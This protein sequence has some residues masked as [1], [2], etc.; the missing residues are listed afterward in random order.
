MTIVE[1]I[2]LKLGIDQSQVGPGLSDFRGKVNTA[3]KEASEAFNKVTHS[4]RGFKKVLGDLSEQSPIL[5]AALRMAI[6][7]VG[8]TLMVAS[9]AFAYFNK[10]MEEGTARLDSLG[11]I[12]GMAFGNVKAAAKEAAREVDGLNRKF[13]EANQKEARDRTDR[14][15]GDAFNKGLKDKAS[16]AGQA[17]LNLGTYRDAALKRVDDAEGAGTISK[18]KAAATKANIEKD[19]EI[20]KRQMDIQAEK[21]KLAAHINAGSSGMSQGLKAEQELQDAHKDV[22]GVMKNDK[23]GRTRMERLKAMERDKAANERGLAATE[24]ALEDAKKWQGDWNTTKI[25]RGEDKEAGPGGSWELQ[26]EQRAHGGLTPDELVAQLEGTRKKQMGFAD[27]NDTGAQKLAD[28]QKRAESRETLAREQVNKIEA[29]VREHGLAAQD[30]QRKLSELGQVKS[31]QSLESLSK[32]GK[33]LAREQEAKI[34]AYA[35]E[36]RISRQESQRK[37]SEQGQLK[38]FDNLSPEGNQSARQLLS[39]QGRLANEDPKSLF[40]RRD[41]AMVDQLRAQLSAAGLQPSKQE[42][43]SVLNKAVTSDGSLRV[44]VTNTD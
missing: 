32:G 37:L 43:D 17:Q 12:S 34:G 41:S 15:Q 1:Q 29:S 10:K 9:I 21:D 4:G 22:L 3:T 31:Y 23:S 6:S 28:D 20:T 35:R 24:S 19:Y 36:H 39:L 26:L 18:E 40:G 14:N 2:L 38:S 42:G 27:K 7:P 11:K 33:V 13:D 16:A 25:R 8:G 44:V 5:G 30:S